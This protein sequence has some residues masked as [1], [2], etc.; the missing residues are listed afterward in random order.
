MKVELHCHTSQRSLCATHPVEEMLRRLVELN[1]DA[2]FLTDHDAVWPAEEIDS[3]REAFPEIA[4]HPGLERTLPNAQGFGH[5]LILGTDDRTFLD[6]AEP[7]DLLARARRMGCPTILAHPS[8][9]QGAGQL[10]ADGFFPDAVEYRTPNHS[11]L[12]GTMTRVSAKRACLRMVNTGDA[13]GLG[14]LGRFWIETHQPFQSPQ[15]L[16]RVLLEGLY[17]N[18]PDEENSTEE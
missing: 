15:D 10:L 2:V 14:Y 8:R 17:D 7:G 13:H 5:L 11:P 6:L 16:R 9:W 4:I 1:Y 3:L 12:Q 18:A